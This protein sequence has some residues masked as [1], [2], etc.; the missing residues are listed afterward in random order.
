M[1]RPLVSVIVPIYNVED[2]LQKCLESIVNQTYANL[3]IILVNDGSTDRCQAIIDQYTNK[4]NRIKAYVKENGGLSDARNYGMKYV[5]G[6]YIL[7]I[8]SDDWID[9]TMIEVLVGTSKR[10]D[11][12]IV[13]CGFYYAYSN[14]LLYDN[15]Y[16][17]ET[18]D[19]CLLDKETAIKELVI[20]ERLK[21][22]AWGKLFKA[23]LIKNIPFK[24]GV[25]FEDVFWTHQI[26]H[27][28]TNYMMLHQPLYYYRQRETSIVGQ[29][30]LKH[31]DIIK[32]LL[33]RRDF[34][35]SHYPYLV[36]EQDILITQ[37]IL[38]HHQLL[39]KNRNQDLKG[40]Y[41]R[42]LRSYLEDQSVYL[43]E[44]SR[45]RINLYWQLRLF[46]IHPSLVNI[47]RVINYVLI[48]SKII[49]SPKELKRIDLEE[50]IG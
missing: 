21:N 30:S 19:P 36:I 45:N 17:N 11:V 7:F 26:I 4:D 50:N 34:L 29:Y 16:Y 18:D 24:V 31:L 32:G 25:L 22:F 8:D 37:T 39:T 47:P 2:Y 12:D 14:Y 46:L 15:R 43:L 44:I 35:S 40:D 10:Y 9:L 13:Q 3:E 23:H 33:E 28:I 5:T 38:I 6:D 49:P 20:N 48:N 41:R 27:S 1:S 42:R